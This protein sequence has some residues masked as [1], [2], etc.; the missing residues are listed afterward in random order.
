M[1]TVVAVLA[2]VILVVVIH[3]AMSGPAGP[4]PT[5][6]SPSQCAQLPTDTLGC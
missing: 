2:L 3:A 4:P 1:R 6:L 5:H